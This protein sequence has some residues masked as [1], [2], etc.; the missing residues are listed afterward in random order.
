[1]GVKIAAITVALGL[2]LSTAFA[3]E[4]ADT[5]LKS[6]SVAWALGLDPIP[7]DALFYAGKPVQG[8]INMVVGLPTGFFFW[9]T[10]GMLAFDRSTTDDS[11]RDEPQIWWMMAGVSAA[12]YLPML[13]W[14]AVGGITG[15]REHNQAIQRRASLWQR[16][17]PTVAVT[18]DGAFGGVRIKF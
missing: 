10:L 9:F 15:V 8:T 14:D 16:V 13:L 11:P 3:Q 18:N 1:V 2:M 5:D 17:Q 4:K 12:A 7:G 6:E